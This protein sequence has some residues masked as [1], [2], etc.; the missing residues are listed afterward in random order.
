[1]IYMSLPSS[2]QI[3]GANKCRILTDTGRMR[4]IRTA[5]RR[6]RARG[7]SAIE[8]RY[9]VFNLLDAGRSGKFA[10]ESNPSGL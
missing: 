5:Y 2:R 7:M 10:S 3:P 4:S 8:A 1:M 9:M 6:M